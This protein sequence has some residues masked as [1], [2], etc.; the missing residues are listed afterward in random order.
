MKSMSL[1]LFAASAGLMAM[2]CVRAGRVRAWR[3]ALNPSAP[4]I[5]DIDFTIARVLFLGMAALGIYFGFQSLSMAADAKWSD[6]ELTRAVRSA[7]D[8][9]DGDSTYSPFE[10]DTTLTDDY[11]S[12][13]KD[14]IA[15]HAGPHAPRSAVDA[16]RT[17]PD[18]SND[19]YYDITADGTDSSFCMQVKVTRDKTG[20]HQEP[21]IGGGSA[22]ARKYVFRVNSRVGDC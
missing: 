2:A 7:T 8:D 20:D 13:I 18:G 10:D 14:A 11:A 21:G 4:A 9:L 19:A 1:L 15:R 17:T 12:T 16:T 3:E 5:P 6:A 22:T